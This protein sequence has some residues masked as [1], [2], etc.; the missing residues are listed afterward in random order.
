[1]KGI[2]A[3]IIIIMNMTHYWK[4]KNIILL[5]LVLK[6]PSGIKL[7]QKEIIKKQSNIMIG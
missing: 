6:K 5:R 7:G 2:L 3:V 1:M 4:Q